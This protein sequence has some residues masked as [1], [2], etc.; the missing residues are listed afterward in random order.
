MSEYNWPLLLTC[1]VDDLVTTHESLTAMY[2]EHEPADSIKGAL[3]CI[4][5]AIGWL[6]RYERESSVKPLSET[7]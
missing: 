6:Q 5:A 4:K 7:P 3:Q 2:E 1:C